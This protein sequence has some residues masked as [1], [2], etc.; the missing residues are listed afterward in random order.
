M[1]AGF[2]RS[3]I[4]FACLIAVAQ[5]TG[6]G[7]VEAANQPGGTGGSAGSD[8][9]GSAGA[10]AGAGGSAGSDAG[11]CAG[12]GGFG[13]VIGA[14]GLR[15][16]DAKFFSSMVAQNTTSVLVAANE[17]AGDTTPRLY[18]VD[19]G[20]GVATCLMRYPQNSPLV[21]TDTHLHV[22]RHKPQ[23]EGPPSDGWI[24]SVAL[25]DGASSIIAELPSMHASWMIASEG[26]LW[27]RG[28]QH[29]WRVPI[30][31]GALED[32]GVEQGA[33]FG[34]A[35]GRIYL[36]GDSEIRGYDVAQG[37]SEV[38]AVVEGPWSDVKHRSGWIYWR[39]YPTTTT[40][41]RLHRVPDVGGTP[42]VL[43]EPLG[44][45]FDVGT[46]VF[47]SG[48]AGCPAASLRRFDPT[49]GVDAE[50]VTGLCYVQVIADAN[51]AFVM[52]N[53]DGAGAPGTLYRVDAN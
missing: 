10:D 11:G 1:S 14:H 2:D 24:E 33:P 22:A 48:D 34:A 41:A 50:W 49:S 53:G 40:P 23:G 7:K 13:E 32:L 12:F 4:A 19:K 8:G 20:S 35:T 45:S 16:L 52:S 30:S 28:N 38:L 27:F 36:A 44:N 26:F 21:L 15:K 9:G 5:A 39:S 43:L 29:F 51:S 46:A 18:L 31:G 3:S 47:H 6:C 37:T 25:A 17:V 42:N